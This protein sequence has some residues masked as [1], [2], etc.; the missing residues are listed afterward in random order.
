M[1]EAAIDCP[2]C[3]SDS[4]WAKPLNVM[5]EDSRPVLGGTLFKCKVCSVRWIEPLGH[6][7]Y[8]VP[9][10]YAGPEFP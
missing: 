3:P 2:R 8:I 10:D 9:D 5:G 1:M 7:A 6:P 4:A